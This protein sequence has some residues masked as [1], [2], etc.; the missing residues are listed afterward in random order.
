MMSRTFDSN[1]RD[2]S[3][4][5]DALPTTGTPPEQSSRYVLGEN[6][7]GR[8]LCASHGSANE[9]VKP[10]SHNADHPDFVIYTMVDRSE[11]S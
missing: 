7:H 9:H 11:E 4:A 5:V 6:Y 8:D 3:S 1:Q 2:T 10:C